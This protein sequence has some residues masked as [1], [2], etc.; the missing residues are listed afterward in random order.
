[1]NTLNRKHSLYI[2]SHVN[3]HRPID[4]HAPLLLCAQNLLAVPP[5]VLTTSPTAFPTAKMAMVFAEAQA[6]RF[7]DCVVMGGPGL[8]LN[9]YM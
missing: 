1:M 4:I 8:H 5:E 7:Y 3:P 9:C 6:L 2:G